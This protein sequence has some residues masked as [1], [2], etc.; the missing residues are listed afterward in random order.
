MQTLLSIANSKDQT[1]YGFMLCAMLD[2]RLID[3]SH[4]AASMD[5]VLTSLYHTYGDT[6][7]YSIEDLYELFRQLG[8]KDV[9]SLM[10]RHFKE[11]DPID[12]NALLRDYGFVSTYLFFLLG[13]I[14]RD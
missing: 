5:D 1:V 6:R 11:T 12:L 8:L 3:E 7:G 2:F 9:D 14:L 4:G 10:Q 13:E